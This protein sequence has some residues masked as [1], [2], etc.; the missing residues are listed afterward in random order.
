MTFRVLRILY[1]LIIYCECFYFFLIGKAQKLCSGTEAQQWD[2]R[3]EAYP[4]ESCHRNNMRHVDGLFPR[5]T[6]QQHADQS[7]SD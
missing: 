1:S 7:T 5:V 3:L 4:R 2:P 6:S